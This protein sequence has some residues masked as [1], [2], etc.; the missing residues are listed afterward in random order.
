MTSMQVGLLYESVLSD[1]PSLN[2]LQIVARWRVADFDADAIGHAWQRVA[3]RHDALRLVLNPLAEEGPSQEL[4]ADPRIDIETLDWTG[5]DRELA[6]Q[7]LSD[8]LETD[9]KQGIAMTDAPMWRVRVVR[10]PDCDVAM[11]WTFHH[12]L[13]D[14]GGFRVVL[15]DLFKAYSEART[16]TPEDLDPDPVPSFLRHCLDVAALDHGSAR[17]FFARHLAGF[18]TPTRLAPVFAAESG[19]SRDD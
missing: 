9:R 14:G 1:S 10:L 6:S 11:I 15:R 13:L 8:W 17:A 16:G 18:D 2:I 4:L 3:R 7:R 5:F 12:A 19:Q